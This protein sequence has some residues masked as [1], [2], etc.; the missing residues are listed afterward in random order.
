[1]SMTTQGYHDALRFVLQWEG[2]FVDDPADPGGRTNRGVTQKTYDAWRERQGLSRR[3]VLV[4]EAPEVEAIYRTGYWRAAACDRLPP[5]LDLV[6]FDTAVN[7]GVRRSI[8]ILQTALE[9]PVDGRFGPVTAGAAA[10]CDRATTTA[11]YCRVREGVY[12]GLARRNPALTRFLKGW[13]NR[14]AALRRAAGLV[15]GARA[16]GVRR[17]REPTPRIPDLAEDQPL[18]PWH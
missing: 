6:A 2:G 12:R 14:L 17:A 1:M 9:C 11:S 8:R 16:P 3:D 10:A 13:V 7:M 4:I 5:P 15:A 18:E